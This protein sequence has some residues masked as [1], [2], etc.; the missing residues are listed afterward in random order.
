LSAE[1]DESRTDLLSGF[2]RQGTVGWLEKLA[3]PLMQFILLGFLPI[4]RMRRSRGPA[5]AVGCG[6]L[7]ITRPEACHL[8]DG[9]SA[10]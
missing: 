2:P 6:R 4:E 7:F 1:L 5:F 9:H 3:I 10:I 8:A